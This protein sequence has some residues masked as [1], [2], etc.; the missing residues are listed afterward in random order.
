MHPNCTYTVKS[1]WKSKANV[2]KMH[3]NLI[4]ASEGDEIKV[5]WQRDGRLLANLETKEANKKDRIPMKQYRASVPKMHS[6]NSSKTTL[7]RLYQDANPGLVSQK[8]I[9][10]VLT[11]LNL[12]G[13]PRLM[14]QKCI[15][16]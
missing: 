9:L 11:R 8:C 2:P 13:N 12:G 14:S 15:P 3:P 10:T 4:D 7:I 16:T 1:G 5:G 6:G